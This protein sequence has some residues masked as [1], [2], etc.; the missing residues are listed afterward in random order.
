[1]TWCELPGYLLGNE[2]IAN[3]GCRMFGGLVITL[4]LVAISISLGVVLG[5]G[6]ALVRL[7][8]GRFSSGLANGFMTFFRGTPLLCQLFLVYYGA[9]QFRPF[10]QDIG[11]WTLFRDAFFCAA[12]TFTLNTAAYQAEIFRGA[13]ASLPRGQWE[14][15]AALGL[16]RVATLI[17]VVLPQALLV[18]LRPLGNEVVIMVKSSA[19]ASL[20]TVFDL[21]GTTRLAF[22]RSFDL[23][24][25]LFAALL[26]LVVVE[27]IRRIWE[28]MELRLTRHLVRS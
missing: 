11:V 26:Y 13:I 19:V 5:L 21:M 27:V 25:Y 10:L 28:R 15:A 23:S 20:V 4:Q 6:L 1:M 8:G 18:A 16:G 12:F 24:V 7:F 22:A 17:R 3:Y 2:A 14:G 9:G